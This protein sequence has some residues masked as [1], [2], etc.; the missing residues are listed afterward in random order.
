MKPTNALAVVLL[1]LATAGAAAAAESSKPARDIAYGKLRTTMDTSD[2]QKATDAVRSG[3]DAAWKNESTGTDYTV[4]NKRTYE[5]ASQTCR[6][7]E[8]AAAKS[9]KEERV[10]ASACKQADGGWHSGGQ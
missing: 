6:D 3:T 5:N 10:K 2:K 7:Y 9:G 4:Q 8:I 1:A